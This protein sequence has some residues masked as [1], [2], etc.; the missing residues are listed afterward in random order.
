MRGI[1]IIIMQM[2]IITPPTWQVDQRVRMMTSSLPCVV[3]CLWP[4][5]GSDFNTIS[6]GRLLRCHHRPPS[7]PRCHDHLLCYHH[8]LLLLY[9]YQRD[10]DSHCHAI[11]VYQKR[12]CFVPRCHFWQKIT[13]FWKNW[14]LE[15]L[16]LKYIYSSSLKFNLKSKARTQLNF[17]TEWYLPQ[18][19]GSSKG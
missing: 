17:L 4:A 18:Q 8:C 15:V 1:I 2:V 13:Q 5:W 19:G 14:G 12:P 11:F 7:L 9:H 16:A 3:S 10:S 6:F